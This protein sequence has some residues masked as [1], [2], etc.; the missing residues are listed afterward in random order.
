MDLSSAIKTFQI[1]NVDKSESTKSIE[2]VYLRDDFKDADSYI[3]SEVD[4][5]LLILIEFKQMVNLQS[6]IFYASSN[7][8][9]QDISAPKQ[10]HLYSVKDVYH[11]FEGIKSLK[12]NKSTKCSS[13]KLQSG[14]KINLTKKLKNPLSFQRISSL[15]IFIESNQK[16]TELTYLN[17]IKLKGS[18]V[19]ETHVNDSKPVALKQ[20]K[21]TA[22]S[23]FKIHDG[24]EIKRDDCKDYRK[25]MVLKRMLSLLKYYSS[26]DT[27]NNT[28]D[29]SEFVEF[30]EEIYKDNLIDDFHHIQKHH[31]H[32][33]Q[34][35]IEFAQ[36]DENFITNFERCS[37]SNCL[38]SHRHYSDMNDMK[39]SGNDFDW[40]LAF[41]ISTIDALHFY[42]YHLHEVGLRT[43][44]KA[45]REY[46]DCKDEDSDNMYYDSEFS[47]LCT[48]SKDKRC[49]SRF[50]RFQNKEKFVI[51]AD[52][53]YVHNDKMTAMDSIFELLSDEHEVEQDS[54]IKTSADIYLVIAKL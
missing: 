30:M 39:V 14:H 28:D 44:K 43:S 11:D 15:A 17:C 26:L 20:S 21:S 12:P 31:D 5:E 32:E 45:L 37:I 51:K 54:I 27:V 2:D 46:E 53:E 10:I 47:K 23:P 16:D 3:L 36:G 24:G 4:E 13:K 19:N 40:N 7:D 8:K 52:Q 18:Y 50:D 9:L 38:Y 1:L 41:Y 34:E 25:C 29:K 35:I 33:L 22:W 6:I 49:S 42:L 48:I